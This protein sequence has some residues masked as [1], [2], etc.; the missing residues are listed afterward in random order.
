MSHLLI[1]FFSGVRWIQNRT[2]PSTNGTQHHD[3]AKVTFHEVQIEADLVIL[4]QGYHILKN[5]IKLD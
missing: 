1:T 4:Y 5:K 2:E 3:F